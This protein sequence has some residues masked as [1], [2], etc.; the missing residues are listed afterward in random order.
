M[1][2]DRPNMKHGAGR[3]AVFCVQR[4]RIGNATE[5]FHFEDRDSVIC[6]PGQLVFCHS[7]ATS[8]VPKLVTLKDV[9]AQPS[10]P[11]PMVLSMW[12]AIAPSLT[13]PLKIAAIGVIAFM[14]VSLTFSFGC[15]W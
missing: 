5:P 8:S 12:N 1:H 11:M 4:G 15:A 7:A 6:P 14:K 13:V 2:D 10:R 9:S 3:R